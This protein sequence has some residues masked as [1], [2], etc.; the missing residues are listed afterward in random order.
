MRKY[1]I[2]QIPVID[3]EGELVGLLRAQDLIKAL[4]DSDE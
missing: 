4:V 1:K 3:F 2:E